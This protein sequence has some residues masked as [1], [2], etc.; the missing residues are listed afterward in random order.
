MKLTRSY[1][2]NPSRY[3]EEYGF[4]RNDISYLISNNVM[5]DLPAEVAVKKVELPTTSTT[6][7]ETGIKQMNVPPSKTTQS[8][9]KAEQKSEDFDS[10]SELQSIKLPKTSMN[11]NIVLP[12]NERIQEVMESFNCRGE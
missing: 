8:K 9:Q 11:Q 2:A 10:F 5:K 7:P 1:I 6:L 3:M 4:I 12:N